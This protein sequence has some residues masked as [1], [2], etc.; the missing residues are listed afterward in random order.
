MWVNNDV[1]ICYSDEVTQIVASL[2]HLVAD[3]GEM[4]LMISL[5]TGFE[6]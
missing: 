2:C 5:H 1:N 3:Y 4:R 6:I